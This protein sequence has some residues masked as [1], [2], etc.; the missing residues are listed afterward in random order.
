MKLC[1]LGIKF[2]PPVWF[3]LFLSQDPREVYKPNI[4]ESIFVLLLFIEGLQA[5][6]LRALLDI[7]LLGSMSSSTMFSP[8]P[9]TNFLE[10]EVNPLCLF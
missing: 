8:S 7:I 4:Y 1:S 6:E 2:F 10:F 5:M 9:S 3:L